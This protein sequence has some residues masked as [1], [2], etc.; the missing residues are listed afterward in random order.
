[1][2]PL[3][4]M[5]E[6]YHAQYHFF[7]GGSDQSEFNLTHSFSPNSDRVHLAPCSRMNARAVLDIVGLRPLA[8]LGATGA[9]GSSLGLDLPFA[10]LG[11]TV[12]IFFRSFLDKKVCCALM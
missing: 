11:S 8:F 7:S 5:S 6:M 9:V 2:R 3:R 12:L 1:M 4:P 10:G